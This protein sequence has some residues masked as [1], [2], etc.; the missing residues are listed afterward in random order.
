MRIFLLIA[1]MVTAGTVPDFAWSQV[2]GN[3]MRRGAIKK[4]TK[5]EPKKKEKKSPAAAEEIESASDYIG[6]V[7]RGNINVE[8]HVKG[9]VRAEELFRLKSTIEGRIE[10]VHAKPN[11]WFAGRQELATVLN[12]ELAA[13]MDSK[14]TTSAR[15][16]TDRWQE[17]Y[18]P[19]PIRC[20]YEC[21]VLKI[22]AR[23]QKW[24]EP[25]ALLIEAARKL[26]LIGRIPPGYGRYMSKG[27]I[28]TFWDVSNPSKKIQA[29]VE[30]F[31]LDVQGRR[32]QSA[33]TFTVLLNRKRYLNP[34]TRW[35]GVIKGRLRKNVLRVPTEALI[36]QDNKA[37]LP[38][39]VSTGITTSE[40]TEIKGG[41]QSRDTFLFIE[42]ARKE[43][44][45]HKHEPPPVVLKA[46]K[47]RPEKRRRRRIPRT[48]DQGYDRRSWP[49][50]RPQE[51]PVIDAF[52]EEER[53]EENEDIDDA[54]PSDIK[55]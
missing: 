17:V 14:V 30:H 13:I 11:M 24:V 36:I 43:V 37:Y 42:K 40:Y 8:I 50:S 38:I 4:Y 31:I 6:V 2:T 29:R 21:F 47:V 49:R 51:T 7:T 53:Q 20:P 45:L 28:V 15:I 19:T 32:V 35:E 1:C 22:F 52:P 33:G 54:F 55:W 25:G 34:G 5:R 9:T 23:T 44:V 12:R 39:R 18:K 48:M 16:L 46:S 3:K 27:Q 41:V 10:E 26:R